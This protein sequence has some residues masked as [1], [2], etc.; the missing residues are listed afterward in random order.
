HGGVAPK[1]LTYV[2]YTSGSTG[3]PK[4]V[5]IEHHSP[6]TFVH[7]ARTLFSPEELSG[8]LAST[9]ICFDLSVFEIFVP[10][11]TGGKV[12][13]AENALQL[14]KLPAAGEVTLINTVPSAVAAL[15]RSRAIPPSAKTGNLAA[16]PLDTALVKR[17]YEQT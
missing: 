9:S 5:A 10:L 16:E 6:V 15:I 14:A 11:S 3:Q 17:I 13:L 12:I 1:N 8:V 4:G 7:W 2:I